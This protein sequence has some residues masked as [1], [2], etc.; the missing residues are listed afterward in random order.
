MDAA[1][2]LVCKEAYPADQ[3]LQ[4]AVATL[5][6]KK[7]TARRLEFTQPNFKAVTISLAYDDALK[8]M[9]C[10]HV[11]GRVNVFISEVA[12]GG[13]RLSTILWSSEELRAQLAELGFALSTGHWS[14]LSKELTQQLSG[15]QTVDP[16][17]NFDTGG[18]T[19]RASDLFAPTKE[20]FQKL[21]DFLGSFPAVSFPGVNPVASDFHHLAV[22]VRR[23]EAECSALDDAISS[24][25]RNYEAVSSSLSDIERQFVLH[26]VGTSIEHVRTLYLSFSSTASAFARM[27]DVKP[28]GYT[29]VEIT[30]R[31][32][33]AKDSTSLWVTLQG[34]YSLPNRFLFSDNANFVA[35]GT[36]WRIKIYLPTMHSGRLTIRPW[37]RA[38]GDQVTEVT[39][40]K[41]EVYNQPNQKR[42]IP[43]KMFRRDEFGQ[44]VSSQIFII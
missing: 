7:T 38:V 26:L 1:K 32:P 3:A 27:L 22:I 4:W 34:E 35:D 37:V 43:M 12:M 14:D 40:S 15:R 36:D 17:G 8:A 42:S 28:N 30:I 44:Y 6:A 33:A 20:S 13:F 29:T 24:F 25:W 11:G 16:Q 41:V 39:L 10:W 18:L 19:L 31:A 5:D 2:D 21:L 23:L 9:Q